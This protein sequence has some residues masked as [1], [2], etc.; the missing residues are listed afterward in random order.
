[1]TPQMKLSNFLKAVSP[2]WAQWTSLRAEIELYVFRNQ[3]KR[4]HPSALDVSATSVCS[5]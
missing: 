5:F 4:S 2:H 1:M 3:L